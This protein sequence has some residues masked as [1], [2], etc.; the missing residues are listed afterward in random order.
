M[1]DHHEV[2]TPPKFTDEEMLAC[3]E[4]GDFCPILFEWYKFVGALCNFF[5]SIQQ[6]SPAVKSIEPLHY[7]GLI[8][9]LNRCSRLMLANVALSHEG[10]FGETTAIIDRCNSSPV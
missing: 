8:G 2:P 4:F 10:L 1:N 3:R 7:A 5:A 9:S 6:D